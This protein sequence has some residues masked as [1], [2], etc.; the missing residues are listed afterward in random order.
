MDEPKGLQATPRG[1]EFVEPAP[2]LF[3]EVVLDPANAFG[4][5]EDFFPRCCAFTKENSVALRRFRRPLL[6]MN[7]TDSAGIRTN[8]RHWIGACC[9]ASA[10]TELE[11]DRELRV[12]GDDFDRTVV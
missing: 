1:I 10:R 11:H 3:D 7:R 9:Q 6:Q 4:G 8:P 2:F 5:F 12:L